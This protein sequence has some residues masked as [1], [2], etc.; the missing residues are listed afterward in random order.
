MFR[1][2]LLAA[3]AL[4]LSLVPTSAHTGEKPKYEVTYSVQFLPATGSAAHN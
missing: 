3:L 4:A 2:A 1:P